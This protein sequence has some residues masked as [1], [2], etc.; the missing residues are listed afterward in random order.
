ML[1]KCANPV[2]QERFRYL[3]VGKVFRV[4]NGPAQSG[5]KET[6]APVVLTSTGGMGIPIARR[7]ANQPE[8]YWLCGSCAGLMTIGRDAAGV[9]LLPLRK[10]ASRAATASASAA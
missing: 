2:C 9:V 5:K 3:H 1:S 10:L 8:Y 6:I 7:V 4:E